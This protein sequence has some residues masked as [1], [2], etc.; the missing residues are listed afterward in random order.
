[1]F[2]FAGCR[3]NWFKAK[4]KVTDILLFW[5]LHNVVCWIK[6]YIPHKTP[7][8]KKTSIVST[9][10]KICLHT[11]ILLEGLTLSSRRVVMWPLLR[12]TAIPDLDATIVC[13]MKEGDRYHESAASSCFYTTKKK[14]GEAGERVGG[15]ILN[16][17]RDGPANFLARHGQS[18]FFVCFFLSY[19]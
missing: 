9:I 1:M 17:A 8:Q 6:I 11:P 18:F 3:R 19:F 12:P 4:F 10:K 16:T 5:L 13:M 7:S 2:F 14:I 15:P